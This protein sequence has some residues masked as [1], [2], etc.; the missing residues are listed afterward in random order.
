MFERFSDRA[1][2]VVVN[3]AQEAGLLGHGSIGTE[4]LLLGLLGESEGVG[5]RAF[6]EYGIT[7]EAGRAKVEEL[8][9]R[10]DRSVA[11]AHIPFTPQAKKA[12]ELSLREAL[13]LGHGFIGTGHLLLG[14]LRVEEGAGAQV[15]MVSGAEAA[16]VRERILAILSEMT[17]PEDEA[18]AAE[19]GPGSPES[20]SA[21]PE[22]VADVGSLQA[23]NLRLK[24]EIDRLRD[25]VRRMGGEPDAPIA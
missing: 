18:L 9:G 17:G 22:P 6:A 3:A 13:S 16:K 24:K 25:L 12:L 20:G 15:L 19:P 23:E 2:R 5:A 4:H 21:A 8:L 11:G 14:L 10:G 1:R 7:L